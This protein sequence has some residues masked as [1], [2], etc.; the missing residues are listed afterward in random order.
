VSHREGGG[1]GD[2]GGGV[3]GN[4]EDGNAVLICD[5][6]GENDLGAC[7]VG[8]MKLKKLWERECL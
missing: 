5:G 7:A 4:G 6:E 8:S 2:F 1:G 3:A